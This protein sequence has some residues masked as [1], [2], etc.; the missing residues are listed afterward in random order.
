MP[1]MPSVFDLLEARKL[2][3]N[4]G[5][6]I[7]Q[8]AGLSLIQVGRELDKKSSTIGYWESGDRVPGEEASLAYAALLHRLEEEMAP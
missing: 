4:R 1:G 6:E 5:R 8:A 7:R 2:I 3:L